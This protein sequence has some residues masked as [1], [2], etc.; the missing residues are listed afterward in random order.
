MTSTSRLATCVNIAERT[1][2]LATVNTDLLEAHAAIAEGPRVSVEI[3]PL[4]T[5]QKLLVRQVLNKWKL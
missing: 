1:S 5:V 3:L 4:A 2:H